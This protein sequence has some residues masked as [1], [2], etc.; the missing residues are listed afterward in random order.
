MKLDM[1]KKR[2]HKAMNAYPNPPPPTPPPQ[3]KNVTLPLYDKPRMKIIACTNA[4][5]ELME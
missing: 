1:W 3:K 5:I 2:K 4:V